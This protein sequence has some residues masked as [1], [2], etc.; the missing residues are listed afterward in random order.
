MIF[1]QISD[2]HVM[3]PGVPA[4][5]VMPTGA[6]LERIVAFL[7]RMRPRPELA[8]VTGDIINDGGRPQAE[9]AARILSGLRMPFHI[10]PGNHDDRA[11]LRAA[12]APGACPSQDAEFLHH[13]FRAGGLR[14]IGLDST[15]PGRPGGRMCPA[16]LSWLRARLAE[17]EEMP[18]ILFL[19]HPPMNFGVLETD[20]DGFAGAAE[21]A[22]AL[23][24][25]SN[26]IAIL[27]GHIHL[28]AHGALGGVPVITAPAASGMRLHLD[29]TMTEPSAFHPDEPALLLHK[30]TPGAGLV[31]HQAIVRED[32]PMHLF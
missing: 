30:W 3:E 31:S 4:R 1:A 19:H 32:E 12:F 23:R 9:E 13:A 11:A 6:H 28:F 24:G 22:E 10:V 27:A 7:N 16:R 26:I 29:L 20:E 2:T 15:W 25:R 5:G 17:D 18:T 14:F 21:L 8:I